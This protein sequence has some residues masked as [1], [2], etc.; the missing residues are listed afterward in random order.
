MDNSKLTKFFLTDT[1]L[2]NNHIRVWC[3]NTP[4]KKQIPRTLYVYNGHYVQHV[5]SLESCETYIRNARSLFGVT[6]LTICEQRNNQYTLYT[7]PT[8]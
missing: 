4:N 8:A 3:M 5:G 2:Q 1:Y 6:D 7:P